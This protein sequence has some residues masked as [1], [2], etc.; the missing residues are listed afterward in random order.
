MVKQLTVIPVN[1]SIVETE[2][3]PAQVEDILKVE[4]DKPH[5]EEDT[6]KLEDDTIR[7]QYDKLNS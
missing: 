5:V 3:I 4:E 6:I 2:I 7:E 1:D